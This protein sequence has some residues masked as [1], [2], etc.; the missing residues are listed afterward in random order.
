M[1]WSG[2]QAAALENMLMKQLVST[3]NKYWHFEQ[4]S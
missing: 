1:L 3:V 4:K 2:A